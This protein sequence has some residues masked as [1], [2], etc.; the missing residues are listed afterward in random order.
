[1]RPATKDRSRVERALY[2]RMADQLRRAVRQL[3]DADLLSAIAAAKPTDPIATVLL[4]AP[5][6]AGFYSD[7]G[8]ELLRGVRKKQEMLEAAGGTYTSGQVAGLLGRS[9]QAVRQRLRRR[10]LLAVPL[11]NGESG[12]PVIQFTDDGVPEPLPS[13]LHAFGELDPWVQLSILL[14][15]DYGDGRLID[16]IRKGRNIP[17]AVRIARSFGVQGAA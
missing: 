14:S 5:A 8:E 2:K 6:E 9:V 10:T 12:F 7:R 1:M 4:G 16:W 13:V 17:E 3:S 11:A 15:D